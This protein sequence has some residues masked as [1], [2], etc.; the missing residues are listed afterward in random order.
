[1]VK[2]KEKIVHAMEDSGIPEIETFNHLVPQIPKIPIQ[3]SVSQEVTQKNEDVM[4][5]ANQ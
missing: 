4:K 5:T 2:V 1:V 3:P